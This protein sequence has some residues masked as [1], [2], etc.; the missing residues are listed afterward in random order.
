MDTTIS[1]I[2]QASE[3]LTFADHRLLG[4]VEQHAEV[5]GLLLTLSE[6]HTATARRF[7]IPSVI[8]TG[9]FRPRKG[10]EIFL[11][12]DK[13]CNKYPWERFNKE[14]I[15]P[16][17]PSFLSRAF[18]RLPPNY[19]TWIVNDYTP[20]YKNLSKKV[21]DQILMLGQIMTVWSILVRG[22]Y[23]AGPDAFACPWV[24]GQIRKCLGMRDRY[25]NEIIG[26][27]RAAKTYKM[28]NG[29][30]G[31][32]PTEAIGMRIKIDARYRVEAEELGRERPGSLLEPLPPGIPK[33][34][35]LQ[36]GGEHAA[37]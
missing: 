12:V 24:Y 31:L 17:D 23:E 1:R 29:R 26:L 27:N 18:T 32:N 13:I 37:A 15:P 19:L 3:P 30:R 33:L 9:N 25:V 34:L 4:I 35:L 14:F 10:D 16:T 11:R 7:G 36:S 2:F 20:R 5:D 22:K 28:T 8:S 21:L 6:S